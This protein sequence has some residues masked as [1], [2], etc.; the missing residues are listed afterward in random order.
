MIRPVQALFTAS[1]EYIGT[2][3]KSVHNDVIHDKRT[4]STLNTKYN[5][6]MVI[7]IFI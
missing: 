2:Y 3:S 5:Y 6:H 4:N 7:Q 1:I